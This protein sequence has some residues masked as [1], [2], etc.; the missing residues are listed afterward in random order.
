MKKILINLFD[1]WIYTACPKIDRAWWWFRHR[2][3]PRHRYHVV[4]TG[5]EPGY[6]DVPELMLYSCFSL[7]VRFVEEEYGIQGWEDYLD[8]DEAEGDDS[9]CRREWHLSEISDLYYWWINE[10]P[11]RQETLDALL[12]E[13]YPNI[14]FPI[15][16]RSR[17]ASARYNF[18]EYYY[19][20]EEIYNL[21]RLM[22]IKDVLWT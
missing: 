4:K 18:L 13:M 10:Y 2:F 20:Q 21:C 16:N 1:W 9:N 7:L 15:E 17:L 8:S 14:D 19:R 5:L 22:R 11:K 12:N 6:Y 3:D